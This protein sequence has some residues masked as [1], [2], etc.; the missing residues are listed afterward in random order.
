MPVLMNGRTALGV[1]LFL[2]IALVVIGQELL[3]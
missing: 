3:P 1:L 2:L